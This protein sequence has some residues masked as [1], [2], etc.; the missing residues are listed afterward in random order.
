MIHHTYRPFRFFLLVPCLVSWPTQAQA[1][2]LVVSLCE[3]LKSPGKFDKQTIQ[4]RG[5]VH[6]AF[7][8]F[9]LR[10][11]ACPDKLP[12]IWLTFGG[13][14]PMPT[15]ST[16][17][18]TVRRQGSA[19]AAPVVGGVPVLLVKDES[20]AR[21][22]A[23]ISAKHG[24]DPLYQVTATLT[25]IFLAGNRRSLSNG[26]LRFPGYGH[27]G[28]CFL[29][30]ISRVD[31]VDS[32]PPPQ[33]D[34]SGAVTDSDGEPLV[35]VDIYSQTA[36]R[37]QSWVSHTR[38]GEAGD[39]AIEN[40]GQVLIFL[41][42]GYSPQSLVLETGRKNLHLVLQRATDDRQIPECREDSEERFDRLPLGFS[43]PE[44]LHSEQISSN[45]DAPF[46]IHRAVG[47]P[48]IRFSKA[49]PNNP[50]GTIFFWLFGSKILTH[51]NV[52]NAQGIPVGVDFR[53]LLGNRLSWRILAI[54][55]QEIVEYYTL[56]REAADLLDDVIDSACIQNQ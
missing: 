9:T 10:P 47:Q 15:M 25:G 20:F 33:V 28:C 7:E 56:S 48:F 49:N 1:R 34:V 38:S 13:D 51:R 31:K 40:A 54:P 52:V 44:G 26:K 12:A 18:D 6:L 27:L 39:F 29:F 30:V 45:P 17:N 4:L 8:D 32:D 16:A 43:V 22:Y 46:I 36:N 21:F 41:K 11:A 42:P 35:G 50:Y 55:G 5:R 14:V 24:R 3:L 19:P 2:P 23:L 37:F 53:G